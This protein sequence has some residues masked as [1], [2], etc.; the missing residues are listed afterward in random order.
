MGRRAAI[1]FG[2]LLLA[3]VAGVL[4]E[5]T[6]AIGHRGGIADDKALR[7]SSTPAARTPTP[8][9]SASPT[10][11]ISVTPAPTPTP[12]APTA[13]TNSFVH[14]RSAKSTSS[15]IIMDLNGGT[16]VELL[17]DVDL[18]W[19]QVRYNGQIGY[20]FKTYLTY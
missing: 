1:F 7:P 4:T 2:V 8:I 10:P 13:V 11:T 18:Q 9:P 17:S 6:L 16:T 19:Q 5:A 14:M 3:I 12:S 20:V 15:N